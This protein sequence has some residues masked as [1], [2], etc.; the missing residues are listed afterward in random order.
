MTNDVRCPECDASV[1]PG[2]AYCQECG[3]KLGAAPVQQ[4]LQQT[5]KYERV[6]RKKPWLAALL[7]V[8]ILGVG[9]MYLGTGLK[10]SPCL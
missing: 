1:P 9:H 6:E 2:S 4:P 10:E 5:Q 8:A 7:G 3:A